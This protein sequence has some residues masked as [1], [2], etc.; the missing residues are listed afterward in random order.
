MATVRAGSRLQKPLCSTSIGS[1]A[2]RLRRSACDAAHSA[3]TSARASSGKAGE[4]PRRGDRRDRAH[5]RPGSPPRSPSSR[6][7]NSRPERAP[8]PARRSAARRMSVDMIRHRQIAPRADVGAP[9]EQQHAMALRGEPAQQ[10]IR[11]RS[12]R[13]SMGGLI[14]DGTNSDRRAVAAIVAQGRAVRLGERGHRRRAARRAAPPDRR[15]GRP[16][17]PASAPDLLQS[18]CA[19]IQGKAAAGGACVAV[20]QGLVIGPLSRVQGEMAWRRR[21]RMKTWSSSRNTPTGGSIIPKAHPTSRSSISPRWS[22]TSANSR[23]STP[24]PAT[25]SPMPC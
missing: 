15:A 4:M 19:A 16:A 2:E 20:R 22:A 12:D 6:R 9:V 17:R 1:S 13:A 7:G 11:P 24:R 21:G 18:R 10:R 3:A 23:W 8:R 5:A 14:S 25:T